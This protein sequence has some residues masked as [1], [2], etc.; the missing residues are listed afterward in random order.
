MSIY[1]D[2][3]ARTNA[4]SERLKAES[5][6]SLAAMVADNP[7]CQEATG[8]GELR[9]CEQH[10]QLADFHYWAPRGPNAGEMAC[11]T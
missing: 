9:I 8:T 7:C 4:A 11:R 3:V 1:E 5:D 6:A 10:W 2:L